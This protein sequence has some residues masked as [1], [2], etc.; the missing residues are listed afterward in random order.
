[1]YPI[2]SVTISPRSAKPQYFE[3]DNSNPKGPAMGAD[4]ERGCVSQIT[5]RPTSTGAEFTVY[6]SND[7]ISRPWRTLG[8]IEYDVKHDITGES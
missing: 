4:K 2:K 6:V 1:M 8:A 7:G 3:V 5:M